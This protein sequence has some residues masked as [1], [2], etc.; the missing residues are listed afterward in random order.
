MGE[1]VQKNTGKAKNF[2]K[3]GP[4]A[5]GEHTDLKRDRKTNELTKL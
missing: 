4:Q 2:M 3:F 1:T 5:I